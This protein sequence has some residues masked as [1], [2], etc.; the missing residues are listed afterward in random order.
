MRQGT[1]IKRRG[2]L[3]SA[4]TVRWEN[5]REESVPYADKSV[6]YAIEGTRRLAWLLKP[7]LLESEFRA[8][9]AEVFT[10]IV[11][12]EGKGIRTLQIKRKVIDLG[13]PADEVNNAFAHAKSVLAKNRH[14]VI[15]SGIH[16]W[17]DVPVDPHAKFRSL[18]PRAAL[19]QLLSGKRMKSEQKEALA[20]AIRAALPPE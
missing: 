9:P 5:G 2:G 20:D 18:S 12:E 15:E 1:V 3:R 11:K 10:Q 13:L 8:D 7:G 17:S 14:L 6:K 4:A 16:T 19:D